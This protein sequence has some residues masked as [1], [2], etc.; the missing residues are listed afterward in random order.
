MALRRQ[1]GRPKGCESR[2]GKPP[3][4]VRHFPGNLV[5]LR[6]KYLCVIVY[7][8]EQMAKEGVNIE[9]DYAIVNILCIMAVVEPLMPP[10]N[11]M[12]NALG[13][14]EGGAGV[15]L[16]REKYKVSVDFWAKHVVVKPG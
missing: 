8:K 6:A 14:E 2:S 13:V 16:D 1:N 9:E 11:V 4:L 15:P 10:I 3:V 12:R 7:D 5:N